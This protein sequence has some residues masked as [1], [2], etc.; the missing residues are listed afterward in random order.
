MKTTKDPKRGEVARIRS[1]KR[2]TGERRKL[3]RRWLQLLMRERKCVSE[4]ESE[5]EREREREREDE[6]THD[7]EDQG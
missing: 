4:S 3:L 5:R 2:K 6:R 7:E 1:T